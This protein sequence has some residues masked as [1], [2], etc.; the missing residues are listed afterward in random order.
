MSNR[1]KSLAT[2]AALT[3]LCS[4]AA[5]AAENGSGAFLKKAVRGDIAETKVGE[6]VQQKSEN[7]DVKSFGQMLVTDHGQHLTE[8]S[9]LAKSMN[10]QVPTQPDRKQR[11]VYDK[12]SKL[13]G[14]A[15]DQ[16][17]VAD[18]VEDHKKDIAEYKKEAASGDAEVA[19]LAK[20]T[21]PVLQKHLETAEAL[22][23]E[24]GQK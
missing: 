2:V 24:V 22:E 6:L 8:V 10:V 11:E 4:G 20:K 19:A 16:Q 3:L 17:F 21:L 5:V 23:K 13:S 12:L 15:F 14:K 9:N 18:M 1:A 7:A